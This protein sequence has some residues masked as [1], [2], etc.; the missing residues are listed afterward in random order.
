ME[1][2]FVFLL[3]ASAGIVLFYLVYWLFLRKETFYVA[4]RWFLATTLLAA[5]A[6]PFFSVQYNI[7]VEPENNATAFQTISNT[8]KNIPII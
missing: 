1:T 4:N 3:K 2:L 6:L 7:F 5:V 8:F